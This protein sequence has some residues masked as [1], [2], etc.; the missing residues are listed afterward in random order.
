MAC[1]CC[2]KLPDEM[3]LRSTVEYYINDKGDK[4]PINK[5]KRYDIK[6]KAVDNEPSDVNWENQNLSF[7]EKYGRILIA[8]LVVIIFLLISLVGTI[9]SQAVQLQVADVTD[10]CIPVE[11]EYG[12]NY[13]AIGE[14]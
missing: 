6:L 14:A 2:R 13:I 11:E 7:K 12:E 3:R 1:L 8:N 10:K 5:E 9:A 4:I